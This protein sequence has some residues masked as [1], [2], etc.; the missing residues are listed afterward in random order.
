MSINAPPVPGQYQCGVDIA[1]E[2]V[3]WFGD[4]GSEVVRLAV[5][6]D[7]DEMDAGP[8]TEVASRADQSKPVETPGVTGAS[9]DVEDPGEFP[10]YG[11]AID[12]ATRLIA[13]QAATLLHVENDRRCGDDW[14]SYRYF[15]RKGV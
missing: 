13:E 5:R 7:E 11:V 1:H 6:V 4:R 9:V 10:M 12:S 15:V 8:A 14:V 2:G 3:L